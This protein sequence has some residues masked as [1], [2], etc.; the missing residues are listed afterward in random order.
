[1]LCW[2]TAQDKKWLQTINKDYSIP[3]F[4]SKN[5]NEFS[6]EIKDD[7]YLVVSCNSLSR[8]YTKMVTLSQQHN[9]KIFH[10]FGR[11]TDSNIQKELDFMCNPNVVSHQYGPTDLILE[12]LNKIDIVHQDTTF[13]KIWLS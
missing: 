12:F 1:M 5:F 8:K 4:Y 10:I 9:T 13:N 2:I 11:W 7:D 6:S 3:I